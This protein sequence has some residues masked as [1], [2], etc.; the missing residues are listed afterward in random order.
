MIPA[1][2]EAKY[3]DV[4]DQKKLEYNV[5]CQEGAEICD[6]YSSYIYYP[7]DMT[8][9]DL[10]AQLRMAVGSDAQ[11]LIIEGIYSD[12][13]MTIAYDFEKDPATGKPAYVNRVVKVTESEENPS[14]GDNVLTYAVMGTVALVSVLG[15]TLYFKKVNE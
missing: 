4:S 2:D 13:A 6:S 15:T 12:E 11:D 5:V 7:A 10:E 1:W 9:E 14:T 8:K 3:L